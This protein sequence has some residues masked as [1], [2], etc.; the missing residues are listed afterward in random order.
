HVVGSDVAASTF[1][2][3]VRQ[4]DGNTNPDVP[5]S[6]APGSETGTDYIL[7]AGSYFIDEVG[8]DG[9][10]MTASCTNDTDNILLEGSGISLQVGKHY[11]CTITNTFVPGPTNTG[12]LVV[13]KH[14]IN[15]GNPDPVIASNF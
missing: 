5:G 1:S 14:V 3:R 12:G 13:I 10:G 15:D 9:F 4:N 11:T 2:V 6:P 8:V 7:P